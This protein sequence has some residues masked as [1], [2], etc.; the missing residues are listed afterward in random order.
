MILHDM[1]SPVCCVVHD[2]HMK[3]CTARL[4]P[5]G[6]EL[7]RIWVAKCWARIMRSELQ[8]IAMPGRGGN[9]QGGV[10]NNLG[11]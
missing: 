3:T 1:L 5:P 4:L 7:E 11:G 8:F 10:Q 2:M 9:G 6:M